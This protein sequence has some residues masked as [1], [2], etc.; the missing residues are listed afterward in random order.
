MSSRLQFKHLLGSRQNG[1]SAQVACRL[2]GGAGPAQAQAPVA[3]AI[4]T[5][6][7]AG[8]RRSRLSKSLNRDNSAL[9]Q[10]AQEGERCADCQKGHRS[11][12]G[13]SPQGK[14]GEPFAKK[15]PGGGGGGPPRGGD[16]ERRRSCVMRR[17]SKGAPAAQGLSI[18][19]LI[20][21][22]LRR[23]ARGP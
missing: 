14:A 17:P 8:I 19:S 9:R 15:P 23:F 10:A 2:Q 18:T 4:T 11:V 12:P 16:L 6:L 20:K 1:F 21:V 5:S 3:V 22:S 7:D 13:Q